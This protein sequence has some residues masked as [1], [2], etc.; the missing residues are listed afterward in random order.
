MIAF[1]TE[2]KDCSGRGSQYAIILHFPKFG[3][4]RE[5]MFKDIGKK[6]VSF[7]IHVNGESELRI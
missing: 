3:F 5:K 7:I 1:E 4:A 2:R 6:Y